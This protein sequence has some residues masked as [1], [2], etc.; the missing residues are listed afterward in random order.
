MKELLVK[1]VVNSTALLVVI[2]V[3]SGVTVD[4]WPTVFVAALVL[5]L[6]NAFLRPI[7]IFLTLPVT[8]LTL[9]LF[10]LVIN[11]FLFYLAAFPAEHC[12]ELQ[13]RQ[14][15]GERLTTGC[16]RSHWYL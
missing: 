9:G 11:A 7:L 16:L 1:W 10:T 4:N 3:V 15:S 14:V 5:G 12:R 6:L 2:H 13:R 8:I